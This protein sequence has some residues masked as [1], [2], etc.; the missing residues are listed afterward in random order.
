MYIAIGVCFVICAERD[1]ESAERARGHAGS[2]VYNRSDRDTER[3]RERERATRSKALSVCPL[4]GCG[5]GGGQR[6]AGQIETTRH[7]RV[8]DTF[9]HALLLVLVQ[10]EAARDL[11]VLPVAALGHSLQVV[12]R[13]RRSAL[14]MVAVAVAVAAGERSK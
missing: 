11:A 1:G 10:E 3:E 7:L 4:V 13:R 12:L 5:A 2:T 14:A 9:E 6:R 8:K